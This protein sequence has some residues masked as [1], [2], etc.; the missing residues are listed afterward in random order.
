MKLIS[1]L[2]YL[3][4]RTY[5][6]TT[7]ISHKIR[8]KKK[9]DELIKTKG[10]KKLSTDQREQVKSYFSS[11]GL[12]NISD[13]WHR[14]YSFCNGQFSVEYIPENLFYLEIEPALNRH[15]FT[16]TLADKNLL[17][18][19]FQNVKQPE[20][21]IKNING[22]YYGLGK[23]ITENEAIKICET[24]QKMIIKPT[25][26]TG[27]G[28]NVILFEYSNG[29]TDHNNFE[30]KKLFSLYKKDFIVQKVVVQH[31]RMALLNVSSLNT[32]R[33]MSF[34]NENKVK[35]LSVVV[36]MGKEGVVTDNSTTGGLSCGVRQDGSL[37][38]AGFQN[39][40]GNSFETTDMGLQFKEIQLP[41]MDKID[42]AVNTLHKKVPY[43]RLISWDMAIDIK[44]EVVLIEY[45]VQGQ[46]INLHQLNNGPVLH[47]LLDAIKRN[48][49]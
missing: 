27:G 37:K 38:D 8:W 22:Y 7:R 14:F 49:N 21:L 30:I 3:S 26:D 48:V 23:L 33:I 2:I 13:Q 32:F 5:K 45:N 47:P 44:G 31:S 36:R 40:T 16:E 46:D 6:L 12:M 19:I 41:F 4:L 39:L 9:I 20:S 35:I 29:T 24:N 18:T 10:I 15:P 17:E 25:L 1:V 34:L 11:F 28:K 42:M 43:F